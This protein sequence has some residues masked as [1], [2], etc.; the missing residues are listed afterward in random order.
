MRGH[1]AARPSGA[2]V[3][4]WGHPWRRGGQTG[5]VRSIDLV[6]SHGGASLLWIAASAWYAELE[7]RAEFE[8]ANARVVRQG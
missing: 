4:R 6:F 7:R 1:R 8:E 5:D 2:R 3:R